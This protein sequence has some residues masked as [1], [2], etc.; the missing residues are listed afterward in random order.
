LTTEPSQKLNHIEGG[1][2]YSDGRLRR[3]KSYFSTNPRS[4][5]LDDEFNQL[6]YVSRQLY[7]ETAFLEVKFSSIRCSGQV[8][9]GSIQH[10]PAATFATFLRGCSPSKAPW[11]THVQLEISGNAKMLRRL[12]IEKASHFVAIADFCRTHP[13]AHVWYM[14]QEP[15]QLRSY[16]EA[17]YY[18]Y[19]AVFMK[20]ALRHQ[21]MHHLLPDAVDW[22][23]KFAVAEKWASAKQVA[24]LD[25]PNF[26]IDVKDFHLTPM[27][28][29]DLR[30]AAQRH[31]W[32]PTEFTKCLQHAE[33]WTRKGF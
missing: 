13:Q 10:G 3:R 11:I 23:H 16:F 5:S 31:G 2:Q 21:N 28:T 25:V 14:I 8:L 32:T 17:H 6:K 22:A 1:H 33:D 26:R 7:A 4:D 27:A 9:G 12:L 20:I 24:R 18:F 30:I 19:V 15:P 29:S